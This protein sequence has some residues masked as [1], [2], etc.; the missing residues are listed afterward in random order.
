MNLHA[1]VRGAINSVNPDI[2]VSIQRSAGYTTSPDGTRVPVY[3]APLA[4]MAQVQELT[5]ADLRKLDGLNIQGAVR[6]VYLN[7]QWNGAVRPGGT[8]GDLLTFQGRV[9]LVT[10]VL[11]QFPDWTHV[12]VTL[13]NG[14]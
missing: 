7:G 12:A 5:A 9:W 8:G 14:P 4:A 6:S 3:D 13:Q 10:A 11:D 1:L 2:P